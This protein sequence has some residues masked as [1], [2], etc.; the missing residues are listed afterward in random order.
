MLS[1]LWEAIFRSI[2]LS[3]SELFLICAAAWRSFNLARLETIL[4]PSATLCHTDWNHVNPSCEQTMRIAPLHSTWCSATYSERS[5]AA[6][7]TGWYNLFA[8]R[9]LPVQDTKINS[10]QNITCKRYGIVVEVSTFP[11]VTTFLYKVFIFQ[12]SKYSG[13]SVSPS[14]ISAGSSFS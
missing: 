4:I 1:S 11:W 8:Q 5:L 14:S 7:L 6:N 2:S 12:S 3:A 10:Y 9:Y 13:S